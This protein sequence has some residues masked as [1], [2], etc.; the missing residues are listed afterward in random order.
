MRLASSIDCQPAQPGTTR[1]NHAADSKTY[2]GKETT[3]SSWVISG[4]FPKDLGKVSSMLR[5]A[6]RSL[7]KPQACPLPPAP[8]HHMVDSS[9][10]NVTSSKR[11]SLSILADMG[12]LL[13]LS[14]LYMSCLRAALFFQSTVTT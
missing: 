14:P 3:V 1:T 11:P 2:R 4:D 6:A 12:L 8:D 10:R 5:A 13:S 9:S 7:Q